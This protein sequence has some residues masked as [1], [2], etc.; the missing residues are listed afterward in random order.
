MT[1][2]ARRKGE[3]VQSPDWL[4]AGEIAE[5]LAKLAPDVAATRARVKFW[6]REGL[7]S[8]IAET[9]PGIGKHRKFGLDAV[10]DTAVL[11]I[12]ADAGLRISGR[13]LRLAL[14]AARALYQEVAA[15]GGAGDT[16]FLEIAIERGNPGLHVDQHTRTVTPLRIAAVSVIVNINQLYVNLRKQ[17]S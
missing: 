9:Y 5:R 14:S 13:E 11:I 1:E 17:S 4:T 8:A 7:I 2:H 16:R 3:R 6:A 12:L 10:I 15:L